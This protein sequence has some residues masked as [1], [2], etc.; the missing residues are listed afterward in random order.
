M[1]LFFI[2]HFYQKSADLNNSYAFNNIGQLYYYGY[3][4]NQ[5]YKIG[6]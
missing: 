6:L 1:A 5:N 3:G 2:G 4:V